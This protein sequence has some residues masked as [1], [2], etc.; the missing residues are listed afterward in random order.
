MPDIMPVV[1]ARNLHDPEG[2]PTP[3]VD[4]KAE[5]HLMSNVA[6]PLVTRSLDDVAARLSAAKP[7]V[8]AGIVLWFALSVSPTWLPTPDSALYL[9]LGRSL[10]AGQGY[11]LD[12]QPHA[13]VPPGFPLLLATFERAGLGSM[14]CLNLI[15]GVIGLLSVWVS[16]KLVAELASRPVAVLVACLLGCNSLLHAMSALQLSDMPFTLLVLTGLYCFLRGLRGQRWALEWGTLAILASCWVRVA[17]VALAVACAVGLLLQPRSTSGLR[18]VAN[19]AALVA[20]VVATLGLFY[21][22]YQHS[23][24]AEH[25]LPPASYMA[26]VQ[27]LTSTPVGSL[28]VRALKNAWESAAEMPRFLFGLGGHP[29]GVLA[30]V[31]IPGLVGVWRR[32]VRREFLILLAVAGYAAGIVLNLPAGDR[33]LLPIAPLLLLYYLEGLSVVLDW[34]ARLRQW[35]FPALLVLI[36]AFVAFNGIKGM[37][38]LYKNHHQIAAEQAALADSAEWL[39]SQALAG[40]RM[41]SFDAEPELSYLSQIPYLQL[42]RC[43]L[44]AMMSRD[45]YL[46]FLYDKNVR[47]VV[48]IPG[49][50]SR[51]SDQGLL[52]E[53]VHDRDLFQP[54]AD[55][56]RF[57]IYRYLAPP[58]VA[59]A[60][61]SGQPDRQLLR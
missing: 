14:W 54:I 17:G 5:I 9:M 36:V 6:P 39:R 31:M 38:L 41:L 43:A 18:V 28:L 34:H 53:A 52:Q 27:A 40:E 3:S 8:A 42:D 60:E 19:A 1:D 47:L 44:T 51:L 26:A 58:R 50:V 35:S 56:G 13:Y 48:M 37:Q 21:G 4:R 12:N 24:S 2:I 30:V 15:M 23:L 25:S 10:A 16:Y 32:L 61:S 22:Q 11:T 20:G 46:H 57:Q 59:T 55:N 33:Y 45:Q 7:Y 49:K 29:L